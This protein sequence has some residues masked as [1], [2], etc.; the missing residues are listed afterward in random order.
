MDLYANQ[1]VHSFLTNCNELFS[2]ITKENKPC[3]IMGDFNLNS[4]SFQQH[5]LTGKQANVL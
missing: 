1:Y 2:K 3:Y 5:S 4:L